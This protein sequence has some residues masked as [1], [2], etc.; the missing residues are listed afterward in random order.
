MLKIAMVSLNP[1]WQDKKAN[2]KVCEAYISHAS[3]QEVELI[4]FPEMTLTGFSM[5]IKA[6]AED[7]N[8]STTLTFFSHLAQKY[9]IAIIFGMVFFDGAFG[10]N[11]AIFI[12]EYGKIRANYVKIHPFSLA[13]EDLYYSKGSHIEVVDFKN[14]H[15]ALSI[16][17]D[18]R[19]APL[20]SIL[21][22]QSD[23]IINIA[24]WPKKRLVHWET[25]LKARAIENQLYMIGVNRTGMDGNGFEYDESSHI[26][27]AN[28]EEVEILDS[29]K[30]LKI[31]EISKD[32]TE[33]FKLRFNTIK[34][35][36]GD[37]Y[38]KL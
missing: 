33:K 31:Y 15:I 14:Y 4:I 30:L 29:F 1:K 16:C 2:Q 6:I 37:L 5:D 22:N 26:F 20:Y 8:D 38:K 3:M 17:Y 35:K 7:K 19:F 24:S 27:D 13:D 25:L 32:K 23:I 34:D 28:G 10:K 12:D 9:H 18:L 21:A 36:R 11:S